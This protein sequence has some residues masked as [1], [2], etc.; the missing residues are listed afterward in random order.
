MLVSGLRCGCVLVFGLDVVK[1]VLLVCLVCCCLVVVLWFVRNGM[2]ID[3][4]RVD[5]HAAAPGIWGLGI[6]AWDMGF[7]VWHLGSE[8]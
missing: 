3:I 5:A 6:G 1:C 8:V 4:E 7:G 2:I